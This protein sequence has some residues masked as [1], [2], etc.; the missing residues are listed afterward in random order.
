MKHIKLFEEIVSGYY[1]RINCKSPQYIELSLKKIGL[2]PN[3]QIYKNIMIEQVFDIIAHPLST[4]YTRSIKPVHSDYFYI[5]HGGGKIN[6]YH[7]YYSVNLS[8]FKNIYKYM[9]Q[10]VID[11]FELEADKYNL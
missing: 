11:D 10:V 6:G 2:T 9:G 8:R 7:W 1:W 4:T 5:S 3:D